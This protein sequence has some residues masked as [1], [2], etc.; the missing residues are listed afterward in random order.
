MLR[1]KA[2]WK[3]GWCGKKRF[4]QCLRFISKGLS[5]AK[6]LTRQTIFWRKYRKIITDIPCVLRRNQ[7]TKFRTNY[8]FNADISTIVGRH[9]QGY[10]IYI[11]SIIH[12]KCEQSSKYKK[13]KIII[14]PAGTK[15]IKRIIE[16][17]LY[18]MFPSQKS[19]KK[20]VCNFV[21]ILYFGL[22][23]FDLSP[24]SLELP[25]NNFEWSTI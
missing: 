5:C 16:Q 20:P 23:I 3:I 18:F 21:Y 2:V 11:T 24:W 12:F 1:R 22:D 6:V 4:W 19:I 14:G 15:I 10:N 25:T 8:K 9:L 17:Y 13:K 7:N